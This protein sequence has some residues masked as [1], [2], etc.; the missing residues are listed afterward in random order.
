MHTDPL[1][2]VEEI[3]DSDIVEWPTLERRAKFERECAGDDTRFI[4]VDDPEVPPAS[5]WYR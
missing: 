3:E 4:C 5:V 2:I 1:L